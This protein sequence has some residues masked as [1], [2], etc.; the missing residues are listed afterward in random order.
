VLVRGFTVPGCS[1]TARL[2]FP[3]R[4][5][6]PV[7]LVT[8]CLTAGGTLLVTVGS[9]LQAGNELIRYQAVLTRLGLTGIWGAYKG[10]WS[11]VWRF[12]MS[13]WFPFCLIPGYKYPIQHLGDRFKELISALKKYFAALLVMY[14]DPDI[15]E[16]LNLSEAQREA[17]RTEMR[18]F[19]LRATWWGLIM[20]GS[21]AV[22]VAT[23]MA[24][25]SDVKS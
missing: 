1:S 17:Q 7:S 18:A 6:F 3:A 4:R 20:V 21:L 16:E 23:C 22:F 11:P 15:P 9:G 10:L 2:G 14:S 5:R 19:S 8:D 24:I 12:S 13:I 25:Y